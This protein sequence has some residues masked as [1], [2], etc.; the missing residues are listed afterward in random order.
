MSRSSR[1]AIAAAATT[2]AALVAGSC[3]DDLGPN[4][5]RQGRFGVAPHFAGSASIIDVASIRFVLLR[6]SDSSVAKDTVITIAPGQDS[7]DLSLA[8]DVLTPGESFLLTLAIATA[9]GDTVFRAGPVAV[10]PSTDV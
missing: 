4:V 9:Q 5:P 1:L 3:S 10:T 6:T 7:V 2:L 8:V